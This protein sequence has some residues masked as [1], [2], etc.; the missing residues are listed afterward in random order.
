[1]QGQQFVLSPHAMVR[2]RNGRLYVHT[3]VK[4][5][6]APFN[7]DHPALIAWICRF[8][9]P[10]VLRD[11]LDSLSEGE[12]AQAAQVLEHL[13]NAGVLVQAAAAAPDDAEKRDEDAAHVHRQ[14]AQLAQSVYD[15]SSDL[16]AIGPAAHAAMAATGIGLRERVASL[17]AGVDALR[18]ELT[19]QRRGYVQGQLA[20][21]GLDG[22]SR[23]LKLHI[24]CGKHPLEGWVNIDVHPAPL[25]LNLK[26]GLPFAD[27]SVRC[28]YFSHLLEH[29]YFPM[30]VKPFLAE[31]KRV[32]APGAV[33][34]IAVPD[35]EKCIRAYVENDRA[36][37]QQR[38]A[39]W[40]WWPEDPTRLEDFL[41]YAGAGPWPA[42]MFESHKFG[43]DWETLSRTL[44][45]AGFVDVRRC[46]YMQ[47]PHQALRIDDVSEV[48]G[49][50]Y[51][52]G[53]HY[54]LFVEASAP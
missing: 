8:A 33:L 17:L 25:A 45:Q 10:R 16:R 21:L 51:R 32:M 4:A 15:L 52:D 38:R 39:T 54:S 30:E 11:V 28:V 5:D 22:A 35:I 27:A 6:V 48:A 14:L 12:R 7:T 37:F 40:S 34:R 47:S 41:A 26:W 3:D 42:Y 46:E 9:R 31:L 50:A 24:G 49:A 19:A 29:L 20:G 1:M 2:A 53:H 23:E 18:A 44:A 13:I 43:Y 36:F